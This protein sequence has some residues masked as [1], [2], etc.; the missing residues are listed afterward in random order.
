MLFRINTLA[1]N[2]CFWTNKKNFT[3]CPFHFR[4][5]FNHN[6]MGHIL[7]SLIPYNCKH[8]KNIAN[9]KWGVAKNE[10]S[11]FFSVFSSFRIYFSE[12]N[13]FFRF[14]GVFHHFLLV[15]SDQTT[16]ILFKICVFAANK[17][18]HWFFGDEKKNFVTINSI[19][20]GKAYSLFWYS[21][22]DLFMIYYSQNVKQ[23][24]LFSAV[25]L[26]YS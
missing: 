6:K 1:G 8:G 14:Y 9:Q 5:I 21:I 17:F 11:N 15:E 20:C 24:Q 3:F 19:Y 12:F 4:M 22:F 2:D 13:I 18:R 7:V 26:K 10:E 23:E 16:N 25:Q